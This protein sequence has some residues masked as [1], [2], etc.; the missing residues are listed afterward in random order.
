M[1]AIEEINYS[2][3]ITGMIVKLFLKKS[4]IVTFQILNFNPESIIKLEQSLY[5]FIQASIL[6]VFDTIFFFVKLE[7]ILKFESFKV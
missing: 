1:N 6:P 4:N 5:H 7:F 3:R 2:N